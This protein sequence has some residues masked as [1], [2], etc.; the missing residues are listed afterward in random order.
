M[1]SYLAFD[2]RAISS[3]LDCKNAAYFDDKFPLFFK[4]EKGESAI[5]IAMQYNQIRSVN[6]MVDYIVHY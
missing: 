4:N 1:V 2:N 5:D 6:L 3:L